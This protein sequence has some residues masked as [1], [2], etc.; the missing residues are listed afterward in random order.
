MYNLG[1]STCI[2][3]LNTKFVFIMG[4]EIIEQSY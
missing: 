3:Y 4:V 2:H 1:K